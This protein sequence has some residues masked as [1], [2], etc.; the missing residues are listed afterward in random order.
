MAEGA[1]GRQ[2]RWRPRAG[3]PLTKQP[4]VR[5]CLHGRGGRVYL[6]PPLAFTLLQNSGWLL[7]ALAFLASSSQAV[8]IIFWSS[9]VSAFQAL[10]NS[11]LL[12]IFFMVESV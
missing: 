5:G 6:L 1:L 2:G 11:S 9:G 8:I 3:R 12:R 4:R 10:M 7:V